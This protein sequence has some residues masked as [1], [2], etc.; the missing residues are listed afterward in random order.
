MLCV[1]TLVASLCLCTHCKQHGSVLL[2]AR[3]LDSSRSVSGPALQL[4]GEAVLVQQLQRR[5]TGISAEEQRLLPSCVASFARSVHH[6][7]H[8]ATRFNALKYNDLHGPRNA[9]S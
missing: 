9:T 2:Q 1:P 6:L 8:R 5:E 4:R 3:G 7:Q